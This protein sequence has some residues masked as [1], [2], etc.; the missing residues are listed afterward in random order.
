MKRYLALLLG[1]LVASIAVACGGSDGDDSVATTTSA[2]P[3]TTTST[4]PEPDP[5]V[6]FTLSKRVAPSDA[7][8][9][10]RQSDDRGAPCGTLAISD[11]NP[12]W[13]DLAPGSEVVV[14]D[15]SDEI[16]GT[17]ELGAGHTFDLDPDTLEFTC[18]WTFLAEELEPSDFYQ[19]ELE[20]TLLATVDAADIDNDDRVE[21]TL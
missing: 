17:G 10:V 5:D 15:S 13:T 12:P 3:E 18:I 14:R 21:V 20:G 1:I 6:R 7:T 19:L 2:P 9:I 4:E 8:D 11:P 16:V